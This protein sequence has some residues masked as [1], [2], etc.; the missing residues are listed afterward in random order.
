MNNC[1]SLSNYACD[2][3]CVPALAILVCSCRVDSKYLMYLGFGVDG[4]ETSTCIAV[5]K[6][7]APVSCATT[8]YQYA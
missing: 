2:V 4:A 7:D 8:A 1:S 3:Y 6:A 5:P